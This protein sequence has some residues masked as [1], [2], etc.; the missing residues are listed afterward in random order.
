MLETYHFLLILLHLTILSALEVTYVSEICMMQI[1][2]AEEPL[3]TSSQLLIPRLPTRSWKSATV[4]VSAHGHGQ[5]L[6]L[7]AGRSLA[8]GRLAPWISSCFSPSQSPVPLQSGQWA[9]GNF[10]KKVTAWGLTNSARE[11]DAASHS[12]GRPSEGL[13]RRRRASPL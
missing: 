11:D 8:H 12:H 13:V 2:G 5:R 6:H 7:R 1:P 3:H 9:L 10:L 4:G